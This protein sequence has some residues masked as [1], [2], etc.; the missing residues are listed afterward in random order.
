LSH[1]ARE[2]WQKGNHFRKTGPL[3]N[4]EP[5]KELAAAIIGMNHHENVA[6]SKIYET[7]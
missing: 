4:C 1:H 6:W 3:E 5:H 7:M 2:A